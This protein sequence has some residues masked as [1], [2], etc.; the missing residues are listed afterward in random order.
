MQVIL[1]EQKYN[2]IWNNINNMFKFNTSNDES[3]EPFE[4]G[5]PYKCYFLTKVWDEKQESI[6]NEILKKISNNDIY[7]LDWQHDCF[8]YNPNENIEFEYHYHDEDRD[9]E[10]YFPTY[11]PN[12]DYHFFVSK[13]FSYGIF[14]HPWRKK[15]IYL[16]NN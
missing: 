16:E 5:I 8:E 1:N 13:D 3:V 15:Y 9:V 2:E 11:F 6:V 7:A 14:G 12:G 10:V 4:F